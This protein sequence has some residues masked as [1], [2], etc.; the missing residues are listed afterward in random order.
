MLCD[1]VNHSEYLSD[2]HKSMIANMQRKKMKKNEKRLWNIKN[3]FAAIGIIQNDIIMS[4]IK[5]K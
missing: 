3:C 4:L 1:M 5:D 2:R